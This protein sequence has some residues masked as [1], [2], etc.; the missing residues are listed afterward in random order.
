MS[1]FLFNNLGFCICFLLVVVTISVYMSGKTNLQADCMSVNCTICWLSDA[2]I[3]WC[4]V[5]NWGAVAVLLHYCILLQQ[6]GA[7]VVFVHLWASIDYEPPAHWGL[8]H[9][10]SASVALPVLLS[11]L[12]SDTFVSFLCTVHWNRLPLVDLIGYLC[13]LLHPFNLHIYSIHPPFLIS[14][15]VS[16]QWWLFTL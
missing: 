2:V 11:H 1:A 7:G 15:L 5:V 9:W 4:L 6:L 8:W 10:L 3:N 12:L 16:E 14:S 13:I